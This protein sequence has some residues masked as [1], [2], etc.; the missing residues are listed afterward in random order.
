MAEAKKLVKPL[1]VMANRELVELFIGCLSESMASAV[2]Q[3]LG[4]N[5]SNVKDRT[6]KSKW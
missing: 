6:R 2:L 4:N 5:M 3:F 1:A